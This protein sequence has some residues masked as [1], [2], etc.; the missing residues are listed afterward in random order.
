MSARLF[1]LTLVC[2][3]S[4]LAHAQSSR[5][6]LAGA[7]ARPQPPA[8]PAV[9]ARPLDLRPIDRATVRVV[10]VFA[11]RA[12]TFDSTATR[13]RRLIAAPVW[14]HGTGFFVDPSGLL[15]TAGHVVAGADMVVVFLAGSDTPLHATVV[16][17]D[18]E[19]DIALLHVATT[20]PAIVNVPQSPRRLVIAESL[21]AAGFPLDAHQRFPAATTGIVARQD[22]LGRLETTMTVNP[23]NSGGPVVDARGELVGLVSLGSNVRAGAQGLA[24]LE[25][26]R[27]ILPALAIARANVA[28][29]PPVH[30]PADVVAGQ[31]I[32]DFLGT[33]D[34]V[35]LFERTSLDLVL[36]AAASEPSPHAAL[37]LA[38]H[39]WNVH[40]ALLEEFEANDVPALPVARQEE[41]RRLRAI[42]MAMTRGAYQRAPYLRMSYSVGISILAQGERSI[43]IREGGR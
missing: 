8:D 23:G 33:N 21:A 35:P 5:D 7:L 20:P 10:G 34:E 6:S 42:A 4:A 12:N 22:N 1:V 3:S 39:A 37:V 16:Y 28:A 19:N 27:E 9:D 30:T 2:L 13:V 17:A 24:W 40:I 25:P 31:I 32:A 41:A 14:G 29:R 18:P 36:R 43:V 26:T 38:A 11:I 15:C